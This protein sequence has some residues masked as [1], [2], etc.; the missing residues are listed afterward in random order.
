MSYNLTNISSNATG[1]LD[2]VIGTNTELMGGW[3]GILWLIG[4]SVVILTSL[5]YTTNDIKKSFLVTS[6]AS[7]VLSVLLATMG[8]VPS[9]TVII[10][11]FVCA[12]SVGFSFL[13]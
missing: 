12:L 4:L 10:C 13:E 1:V 6:F 3:L 7:A 8:L 5:I 9:I 2:I 11:I